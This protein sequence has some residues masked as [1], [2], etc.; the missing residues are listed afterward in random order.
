MGIKNLSKLL[1]RIAPTCRRE[2]VLSDYAGQRF[3]IDVPIYMWKFS[4][5]TGGHPLRCFRE[6]LHELRR[7][8]ILPTYV[9]DGAAAPAKHDEVVRRREQR[10]GVRSALTTARRQYFEMRHVRGIMTRSQIRELSTV[11]QQYE[12]LHRRV[13]SVPTRAHYDGLRAFL[14]EEQVPFVEA[15]G[16]AEKVCAELVGRGE[17][18]AVVTDDYDALVYLCTMASGEGRMVIGLNRPNIVEYDV[19]DMLR[20]IHLEPLQFVDVCILS[21]CDFC[22]KIS[23]VACNRAFQLV[24]EHK[25][26]ETILENLDDKFVVPGVFDYPAARDQFGCNN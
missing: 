1:A 2:K 22:N 9:F 12:K 25:N 8:G 13:M 7:Y 11:K 18:D 15:E 3:A 21:G 5:I 10:A 24:T 19:K 4:S 14:A 17:V 6:Q 20:E 26:I 16:D 23:G